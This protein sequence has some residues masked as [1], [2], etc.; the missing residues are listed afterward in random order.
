MNDN[1]ASSLIPLL[2]ALT[3]ILFDSK[4]VFNSESRSVIILHEY[5]PVLKL[6]L[7]S[8][9]NKSSILVSVFLLVNSISQEYGNRVIS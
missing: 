4:L 3:L 2:M 6:K 5:W 9:L 1:F 8:T 7:G